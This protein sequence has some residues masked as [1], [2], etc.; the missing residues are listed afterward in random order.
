MVGNC[1]ISPPTFNIGVYCSPYAFMV[2]CGASC[3]RSLEKLHWVVYG[4][5]RYTSAK[6]AY[7][8]NFG[9]NMIRKNHK[10]GRF[11]YLL[12]IVYQNV[13]TFYLLLCSF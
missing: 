6:I 10:I 1:M 7:L 5:H 12:C 9:L 13:A 11:Y 2:C 4:T 8:F 3:S